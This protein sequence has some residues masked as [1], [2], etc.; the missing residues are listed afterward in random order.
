MSP[1][2]DPATGG[3]ERLCWT[4]GIVADGAIETAEPP[5]GGSEARPTQPIPI[6]ASVAIRAAIR[7]PTGSSLR[8][9]PL[10]VTF[11]V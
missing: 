8:P 7:H 9:S 3:A 5:K 11:A 10:L 4:A 2:G 6:T 1:L